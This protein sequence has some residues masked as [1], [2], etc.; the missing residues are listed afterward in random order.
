MKVSEAIKDTLYVLHMHRWVI[1]QGVFIPYVITLLLD[2]ITFSEINMIVSGIASL[3][4]IPIYIY[5]AIVVHRCIILGPDTVRPWGLGKWTDRE[6]AFLGKTIA[7]AFI[8]ILSFIPIIMVISILSS[9]ESEQVSLLM[10]LILLPGFYLMAR[11]SLVF[12]AIAVDKPIRFRDSWSLSKKNHLHVVVLVFLIPYV[13]SLPV[14]FL[15]NDNISILVSGLYGCFT[16]IVTIA[17]LSKT[18]TL[19]VESNITDD[20]IEA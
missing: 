18:Y 2:I 14:Q 4:N 16:T 5:I 13:I 10:H 3:L 11:F 7:V 20:A 12:P 9:P 17:F 6:T 19:C 15:G 1:L 8:L